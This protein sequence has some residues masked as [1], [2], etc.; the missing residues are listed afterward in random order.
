MASVS[1]QRLLRYDWLYTTAT[2]APHLHR[3]EADLRVFHADESL[4]LDPNIDYSQIRGLS[5][6]VKERLQRVMPTTL[7]AAK[8]MEGMTPAA[9]VYLL[10]H[11]RRT[12]HSGS[13][14]ASSCHDT[15]TINATVAKGRA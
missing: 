10:K 2:Y 1:E 4:L 9:I 14:S 3:Q 7:G 5:D 11:A 6:E 15:G 8:R 13:L 12:W